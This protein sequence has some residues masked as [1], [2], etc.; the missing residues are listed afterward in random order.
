MLVLL[1][2]H[3]LH[4]LQNVQNLLDKVKSPL[5]RSPWAIDVAHD[6]T[7]SASVHP[8]Y[9]EPTEHIINKN[10]FYYNNDSPSLKNGQ[11]C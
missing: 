5:G 1:Q 11:K 3:N 6:L 8:S 7:Y 10:Q 9:F 4:N 2:R